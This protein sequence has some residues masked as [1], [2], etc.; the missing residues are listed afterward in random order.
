MPPITGGGGAGS[1]PPKFAARGGEGGS[2]TGA[3]SAIRSVEDALEVGPS[4]LVVA[5]VVVVVAVVVVAVVAVVVVVVAVVVVAVVAVAVPGWALTSS[6]G[7][8]SGFLL[9]E[10][11]SHAPSMPS[12]TSRGR[13]LRRKAE[14]LVASST[15]TVGFRV[16]GLVARREKQRA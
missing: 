2:S 12:V 13:G 14:S 4:P 6:L 11:G 8:P 10:T 7:E 15:A 1:L 3:P 9:A 16:Q 5:V